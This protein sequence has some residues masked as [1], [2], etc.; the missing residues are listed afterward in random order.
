MRHSRETCMSSGRHA[1]VTASVITLASAAAPALPEVE[2]PAA[3][4]CSA[5]VRVLSGIDVSS[6]QGEV[7]WGR[8]KAAGVVFAFARVSDGLAVIDERFAG[9]FAAMRRV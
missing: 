3:A 4:V 8:V 5:P 6:F 9:N 7:D 2:P 1:F